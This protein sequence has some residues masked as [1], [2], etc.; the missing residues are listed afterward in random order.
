MT[1]KFMEAAWDKLVQDLQVQQELIPFQKGS[2]KNW[3][4][5]I[6]QAEPRQQQRENTGIILFFWQ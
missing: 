2:V 5:V 3:I 4:S 1:C 6:S